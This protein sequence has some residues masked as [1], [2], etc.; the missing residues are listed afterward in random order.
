[1]FRG[2]GRNICK[3]EFEFSRNSYTHKIKNRPLLLGYEGPA[4]RLPL[5]IRFINTSREAHAQAVQLCKVEKLQPVETVRY[6]LFCNPN[7]EWLISYKGEVE[8]SS[9]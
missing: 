7:G 6:I 1:M 9:I 4:W 2:F 5:Q 3:S 8:C